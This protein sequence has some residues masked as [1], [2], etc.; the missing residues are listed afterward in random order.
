[1]RSIIIL[2]FPGRGLGPTDP[3]QFNTI[4]RVNCRGGSGTFTLA[5]RGETTRPI[6]WDSLSN[7]VITELEAL[8]TVGVGGVNV[9][10]YSVTACSSSGQSYFQVEFLQDFGTIPLL[11]PNYAKLGSDA[12]IVVSVF[13]EG[14]KVL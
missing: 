14:H 10:L 2:C 3:V 1:M 5:F 11:V 13:Q 8:P 12:L 9:I 7:N 4:Q 6:P